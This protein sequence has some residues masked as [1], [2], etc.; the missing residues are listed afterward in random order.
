[1][2]HWS[3]QLIPPQRAQPAQLAGMRGGL[4]EWRAPLAASCVSPLSESRTQPAQPAAEPQ[5]E[6]VSP[7][8]TTIAHGCVLGRSL[9]SV[10]AVLP[11]KKI[12]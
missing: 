2:P 1:M 10:Q 6:N 11:S 12:R 8:K 4:D 7:Q 3:S 9:L 5:A